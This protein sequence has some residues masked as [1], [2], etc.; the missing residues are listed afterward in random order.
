MKHERKNAPGNGIDVRL[1]A[2]EIELCNCSSYYS[3]ITDLILCFPFLVCF[4]IMQWFIS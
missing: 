4:A 3:L 2:V 1:I